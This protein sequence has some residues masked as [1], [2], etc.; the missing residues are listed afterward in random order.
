M[1][2]AGGFSAKQ[3]K[4]FFRK[5]CTGEITLVCQGPK[6]HLCQLS[7]ISAERGLIAEITHHHDGI[8]VKN[9]FNLLG[10]GSPLPQRE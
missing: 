3:T 4:G 7:V 8:V 1:L 6:I 9:V 10:H 2:L 5:D